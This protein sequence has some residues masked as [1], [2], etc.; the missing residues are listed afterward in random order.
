MGFVGFLLGAFNSIKL[1]IKIAFDSRQDLNIFGTLESAVYRLW[2]LS[3]FCLTLTLT[4]RVFKIV[5]LRPFCTFVMLS[6]YLKYS[7][8]Q[9]VK[10]FEIIQ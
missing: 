8:S 7:A 2:R 5:M 10:S 4:K 9:S 6:Q 1:Y 3:I